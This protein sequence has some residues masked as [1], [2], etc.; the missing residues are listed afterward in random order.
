MVLNDSQLDAT[1]KVKDHTLRCSDVNDLKTDFFTFTTDVTMSNTK[2]LV[3]Y[4]SYLEICYIEPNI[5][6]VVLV[7]LSSFKLYSFT[8]FD[9]DGFISMDCYLVKI[10]KRG[11]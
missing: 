9:P 5:Y 8:V 10:A 3:K 2:R 1:N 11:G 7:N 6:N 4:F